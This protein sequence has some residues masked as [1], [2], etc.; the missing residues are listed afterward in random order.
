[1]PNPMTGPENPGEGI[2]RGGSG[3][4]S[5]PDHGTAQ[6]DAPILPLKKK[7]AFTNEDLCLRIY[8]AAYRVTVLPE[9]RQ[10]DT[11]L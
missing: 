3:T 6:I 8:F 11:W 2:L 1:M 4:D 9:F 7:K 5:L 10:M